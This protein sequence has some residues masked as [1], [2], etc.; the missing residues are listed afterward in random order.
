MRQSLHMNSCSFLLCSGLSKCAVKC[1]FCTFLSQN[2][3]WQVKFHIVKPTP[4][5]LKM[6]RNNNHAPEFTLWTVDYQDIVVL[7]L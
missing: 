7:I 6:T 5:L 2:Q 4:S 1:A 3:R